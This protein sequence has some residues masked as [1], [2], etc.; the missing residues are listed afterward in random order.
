MTPTPQPPRRF[1][2]ARENRSDYARNRLLAGS[3]PFL[4]LFP[5]PRISRELGGKS[6]ELRPGAGSAALAVFARDCSFPASLAGPAAFL[7]LFP[8]RPPP[9]S[10]AGPLPAGIIWSPAMDAPSAG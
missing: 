5:S 4:S 8:A 6:R 1:A 3:A 7:P 2:P 9:P 10:P